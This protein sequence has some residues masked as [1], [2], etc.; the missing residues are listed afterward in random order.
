M[1]VEFIV[2]VRRIIGFEIAE[3]VIG[4]ADGWNGSWVFLL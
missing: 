1:L 3:D 2:L 4:K